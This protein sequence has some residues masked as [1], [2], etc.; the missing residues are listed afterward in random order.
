M[1]RVA[2]FLLAIPLLVPGSLAAASPA[3]EPTE[4]PDF[5]R[6]DIAG[7]SYRLAGLRGHVVLLNFWATW[8]APCLKEMPRFTQWQERYGRRGLQILGVSMDDSPDPVRRLVQRQPPAYPV[9]MGDAALAKLYGGVYGLPTT[10]LIDGRGRI[11][12]RYRGE[13]NLDELEA[14]IKAFLPGEQRRTSPPA[15]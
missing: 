8:C 9:I 14:R 10:F 12:A 3:A 11:V 15:R 5:N 13:A 4:A 2:A 1:W 7:V 6:T